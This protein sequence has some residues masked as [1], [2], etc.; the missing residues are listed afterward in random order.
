M[1]ISVKSAF[2]GAMSAFAEHVGARIERIEGKLDI[3]EAN[4]Q[5]S[6]AEKT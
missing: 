2:E 4:N 1:D 5:S 3:V 6:L